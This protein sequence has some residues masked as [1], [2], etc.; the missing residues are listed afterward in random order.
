ML[1]NKYKVGIFLE[2]GGNRV[3]FGNGVL[4][5]LNREHVR[6]EYLVGFSSSAPVI[7]AYLLKKN[8]YVARMFARALD[9]N[10]KN[11]YLF[12]RE[13]FPHDGIYRNAVAD[14]LT[15]FGKDPATSDFVILGTR[16]SKTLPRLK[17]LLSTFLLVLRHGLNMNLLKSF[18]HLFR[19]EEMR[20]DKKNGLSRKE[21]IEF[22]MGTSTLYPFIGL[23]YVRNSLVLEGALLDPD[24]RKLLANCDK[25][26]VIHTEQGTT[27]VM[28]DTLH[29]CADEPVPNNVLDYTDGSKVLRLHETGR[30]VMTKHLP[31]V[32]KFIGS[33]P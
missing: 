18:R 19:M 4:D 23:H 2:A 7:F 3:F 15:D 1:Q 24:Y 32:R 21:L 29:I 27:E 20:I 8:D 28:G 22:I 13:H 31:L 17:A 11:F 30:R 25:R 26:I 12:R 9:D 16:T 33:E 14:I 6:I 10:K 5:V